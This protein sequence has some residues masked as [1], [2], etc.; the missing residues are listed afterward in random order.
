MHSLGS[1]Y[2]ELSLTLA[3][4]NLFFSL[5]EEDEETEVRKGTER[6]GV[7]CYMRLGGF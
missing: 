4:E 1:N 3:K 6:S 7:L 5:E 2:V